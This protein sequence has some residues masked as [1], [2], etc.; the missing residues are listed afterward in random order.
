MSVLVDPTEQWLP[1]P[2]WPG[3]IVS[4]LGRVVSL[5]RREPRELRT[6]PALG[7]YRRL[8]L[9]D[10]VKRRHTYFVHQLVMLA[11]VGPCPDGLETRHLEGDPTDNRLSG[12][13]YGTRSENSMDRIAHGTHP[14]ASRT[15]CPKGH[16]YDEENTYT[17]PRRG[18]RQCLACKR[19]SNRRRAP[20]RRKGRVVKTHCPQGHP[21]DEDNTVR[22]V[23]SGARRCRTCRAAQLRAMVEKKRRRRLWRPPELR[24]RVPVRA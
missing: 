14:Q 8:Q 18:W 7:G 10:G 4:D 16:P 6:Y 1:V 17:D 19:D 5:K 2:D 11:F 3:Y 9:S 12:L 21:Y 22:D 13:R 24:Q 15:H 23:T 20:L